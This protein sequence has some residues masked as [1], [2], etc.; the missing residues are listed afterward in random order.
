MAFTTA[1]SLSVIFH[2]LFFVALVSRMPE[3]TKRWKKT[4]FEQ[5]LRF[6]KLDPLVLTMTFGHMLG[7]YQQSTSWSSTLSCNTAVHKC[8]NFLSPYFDKEWST[9]PGH[10][11]SVSSPSCSLLLQT[12]PSLDSIHFHLHLNMSWFPLVFMHANWLSSTSF[13]LELKWSLIGMSIWILSSIMMVQYSPFPSS[14]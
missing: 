8:T 12:L 7:S 10:H 6:F 11:D 2:L 4:L 3:V 9:R 14:V 5:K 13:W 1:P